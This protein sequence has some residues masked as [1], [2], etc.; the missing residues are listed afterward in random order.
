MVNK[1]ESRL[2]DYVDG[3][4][5]AVE[6]QDFEHALAKDHSLE[7]AL[8]DYYQ[9]IAAEKRLRDE[10]YNPPD[11]LAM[12]IMNRVKNKKRDRSWL[13]EVMEVLEM[14][15][16]RM[17]L[18]VTTAAIG[19]MVLFIT[20]QG[21]ETNH[22]SVAPGIK[23]TKSKVLPV[24][25]IPEEA[26]EHS[27]GPVLTAP[28]EPNSEQAASAP[29]AVGKTFSSYQDL[30]GKRPEGLRRP[31]I[32]VD[33]DPPLVPVEPAHEIYGEYAEQGR[34]LTV[35]EGVSTFSIDI[36]T[37]SYTNV[38]RFLRQGQM[39]PTDSVRVEEFLNYFSYEYPHDFKGPFGLSYELAPA[40]FDEG[41]HLLR[42]NL[43]TRK[44]DQSDK[45][46]NLVFL[47]DV[48]G[49]MSDTDKLP[50]VKQALKILV[51]NMRT[52]D[53]VAIVT[54]AGNAKLALP[55]STIQDKQKILEAIDSL[56]AGGSTYGSGGIMKA[57]EVAQGGKVDSGI[58]RIVLAT[59]GD[60]NVGTTSLSQLVK[61][62]E[63]KRRTGIY[64]TTLGFGQ[65]N[66]HED[67]ME[68]LANKGNGNYF[69][70]DS[71]QEAR[72][73]FETDLLSTVETVAKDVKIQ[74]EFNPELVLEYRLIGYDNRKLRKQDFENDT[75]DAGEVGVNHTVTALYELVL[76]DSPI[77]KQAQFVS[78]YQPKASQPTLKVPAAVAG[79]LAFLKVRYK[80][81]DGQSSKLLEFPLMANVAKGS[82]DEASADFRFAAAVAAFGQ[83]LK[84]S[85][86]SEGYTYGQIIDL[87]T[88]A[89]GMDPFGYRR[90]FIELV[91]NARTVAQE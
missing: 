26:T 78:R 6:Q 68:Q 53:R 83:L 81:P 23:D 59:D 58:N 34:I 77:A 57:Y 91:R 67:V 63:D 27:G 42:L 47:V 54:Y 38:R 82:I 32:F 22:L 72:K 9:T 7:A 74:I 76:A 73:V 12:Q 4:L 3:S 41:R 51:A 70:I 86:F 15:N 49:S 44:S 21:M 40:P 20:W 46:W 45:A 52:E 16:R 39:P 5:T 8:H 2:L 48:S 79:E 14:K 56:G 84:S 37:G 62:V 85:Q 65:G 71:F 66:Y 36:D 87:A 24:G 17:M 43:A 25:P 10:G 50:L 31:E 75:V 13:T 33:Y 55:S 11:N 1:W 60:F 30:N 64:L 35:D 18:G 80:Q 28:V 89:R 90:E 88:D 69:Y 19:V 29:I 61:L